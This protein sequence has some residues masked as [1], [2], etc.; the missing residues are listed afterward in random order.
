MTAERFR[1]IR[2]VFEAAL[3]HGEA[4]R[5]AWLVEACQGDASLQAEVDALLQQYEKRS[6][7]LDSPAVETLPSSRLEG[8]RV[9]AWE[10]CGRSAGAVWRWF[11]WRSGPTE[12]FKCKP[13][14]KF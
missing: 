12:L 6:G 2:N 14:S 7:V 3:D 9:G 10:S 4:D 11:I 8:R 13:P 5:T 1:Q